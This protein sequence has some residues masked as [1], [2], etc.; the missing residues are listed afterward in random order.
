MTSATS[1][2]SSSPNWKEV[3][4]QEAATRS[5]MEKLTGLLGLW[6]LRRSA[7]EQHANQEAESK[8]ARKQ[9]GSDGANALTEADMGDMIAGNQ[10]IEHHYH[11]PEP[12]AKAEPAT[13]ATSTAGTLAKLAVGAGML[14]TGAGAGVGGY[15]IADALKNQE[16]TQVIVEQPPATTVEVPD[17]DYELMLG[18]PE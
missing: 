10:T 6:G 14:A 9:W 13:P 1:P 12:P 4:V 15:L 8:W 17:S 16:P 7:V 5:H 11:Y 18:E 2:T 3:T